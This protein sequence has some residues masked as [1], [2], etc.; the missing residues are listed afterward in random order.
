MR[1][2]LAALLGATALLASTS[3]LADDTIKRPGDHPQYAVEIEPHLLWG[4]AQYDYVAGDGL[5][6]GAR[7]SIPIVKNGF[8]P[9]INNSVAISFGVD[10]LH[11]SADN[12][13]L[14][15]GRNRYLGPCWAVGDVNTLLFP[16]VMQW[17]FFV[18]KQW[19]VFGEPGLVI[20][21][22][23]FDP[24]GNAPA[25]YYCGNPTLTGV[26]LALYIGGRFHIN[27]HVALVLR[28]GYPTF[29]FGVSFM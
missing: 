3:A 1:T 16:V 25:G 13:Y 15:G 21:H 26:D 11:Y 5:G 20:Y 24:C 29:S 2:L 9:S 22:T 17:N 18:G 14:Y 27:D 10:W 23:F 4:W 7:F 6:L 8:I 12:C 28:I 19:S